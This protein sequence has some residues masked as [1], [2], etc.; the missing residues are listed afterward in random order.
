MI[1][2]RQKSKPKTAFRRR[3]E[4]VTA[5]PSRIASHT[6]SWISFDDAAKALMARRRIKIQAALPILRKACLSYEVG[7]R[8]NPERLDERGRLQTH[9]TTPDMLTLWCELRL[10]TIHPLEKQI[11]I[12]ESDL[13]L[14]PVKPRRGPEPGSIARFADDDGALFGIIERAMREK[15]ITLTEAV[16][17]LDYEGKVKGRGSA[18]SRIRRVTRSYRKER[19]QRS[20]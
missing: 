4:N 13:S 15:N 7:W 14:W 16:R 19:P 18:E 10:N 5:P 20:A 6:E 2:H 9:W 3:T 17:H 1:R 8:H 11:E 12:R